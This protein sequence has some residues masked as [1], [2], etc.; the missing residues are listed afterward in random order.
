[1]KNVGKVLNTFLSRNLFV[2]N[3][4]AFGGLLSLGDCFSQNLQNYHQIKS[5]GQRREYDYARTGRMFI[6]GMVLGPFGH[7]FYASLDKFIQGSSVSHVLRKIAADQLIGSPLFY[8]GFLIGG[9]ALEGKSMRQCKVELKEKF[10]TIYM[11][12]CCLWPPA[13]FINFYFL[14]PRFRLIYISALSLVWNT[15]LSYIKHEAF[16]NEEEEEEDPVTVTSDVT[17]DGKGGQNQGQGQSKQP[18]KK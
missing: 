12:D 8:S 1:M 11:A 16:D 18:D 15:Y 10:S 17:P 2:T 6:L 4:I 7:F 14:P 13:Q 9:G 3:V 5:T